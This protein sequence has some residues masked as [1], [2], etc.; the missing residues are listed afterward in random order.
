MPMPIL[1]NQLLIEPTF[2]IYSFYSLYNY[3]EIPD[4]KKLW[5]NKSTQ[6]DVPKHA[7]SQIQVNTKVTSPLASP[8]S[9]LVSST[10]PILRLPE[11]KIFCFIFGEYVPLLYYHKSHKQ[12]NFYLRKRQNHWPEKDHWLKN[13]IPSSTH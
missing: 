9:I 6:L 8:P 12:I 1:I 11:N 13:K 10:F 4:K 7:E 2:Q 3:D 5:W